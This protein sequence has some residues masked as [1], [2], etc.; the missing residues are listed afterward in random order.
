M[1]KT[2]ISNKREIF[3]EDIKSR[4]EQ[5]PGFLQLKAK[6][7]YGAGLILA[8]C[9]FYR[10]KVYE[11][12]FFLHCRVRDRILGNAFHWLVDAGILQVRDSYS[13]AKGVTKP[14]RLTEKARS[15]IRSIDEDKPNTIID[16]DGKI[17]RIPAKNAIA[18]KDEHGK[19]RKGIGNIDAVVMLDIDALK[20]LR[21]ELEEWRF[22]LK[23]SPEPKNQTLR[24]RL[25]AYQTI[26]KKMKF[27]DRAVTQI[28]IL[29]RWINSDY[30]KRGEFEQL[31]MEYQSGRIYGASPV[32]LQNAIREIRIAALNGAYDY[33][34]ENAHFSI[35]SQ[36]SERLGLKLPAIAFYVENK[37]QVREDLVKI[38]SVPE[39]VVKQA[40]VALAYG[41]RLSCNKREAIYK[42]FF[43]NLEKVLLFNNHEIVRDICEDIK[44]ASSVVLK[45]AHRSRGR[46]MNAMGKGIAQ[47]QEKARIMAHLLQGVEAQALNAMIERYGSEIVLLQHDGWTSKTRLDVDEIE[48]LVQERTGFSLKVSEELLSF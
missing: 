23:G 12:S 45:N 27:I 15:L 44:K 6:E 39:S 35:L 18:S 1:A 17:V 10:H 25:D 7:R 5:E 43:K 48:R 4:L 37:K 30:L 33:D 47:D 28:Q 20:S 3:P 22:H 11:D 13:H 40:I 16:L 21:D 14:Y 42:K 38:L 32:N 24:S 46:V 9:D 31:Y 29:F 26:Q 19:T 2:G 41:A 34:L 8:C 36:M